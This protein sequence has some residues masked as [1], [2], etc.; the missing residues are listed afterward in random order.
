MKE[1]KNQIEIWERQFK[2][3]EVAK[4]VLKEY[5]GKVLNRRIISHLK[6][7]LPENLTIHYSDAY[8]WYEIKIWGDGIPYDNFVSIW[9]CYKSEGVKTFS[10]ELIEKHGRGYSDLPKNIEKLKTKLENLDA[11]LKEYEEIKKSIKNFE[12]S[13]ENSYPLTKFFKFN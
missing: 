10:M 3:Y 5:E 8:S 13:L 2:V 1:C 4:E 12:N 9:L 6:K 11:I 7:Y